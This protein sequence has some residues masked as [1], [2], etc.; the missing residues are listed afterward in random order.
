MCNPNRI[1]L[2][3]TPSFPLSLQLS[4]HFTL[5]Y[6]FYSQISS[7]PEL[8]LQPLSSFC[9][10][11]FILG[12]LKI[13]LTKNPLHMLVRMGSI[14]VGRTWIMVVRMGSIPAERISMET[15]QRAHQVTPQRGTSSHTT[16]G[17]DLNTYVHLMTTNTETPLVYPASLYGKH[18]N[19]DR[20]SWKL[21]GVGSKRKHPNADLNSQKLTGVARGGKIKANHTGGCMLSEVDWG[22]H[23]SSLFFY[24]E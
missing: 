7:Q 3:H 20:T 14:P 8:E 9:G 15:E 2:L 16:Q 6:T 13:E 1:P 4:S 12:K 10:I 17:K 22:A 23:E 11:P 5:K 21:T 18:P 19:V 24:L